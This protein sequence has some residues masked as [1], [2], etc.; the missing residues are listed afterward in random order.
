MENV[1]IETCWT[2]HGEGYLERKDGKK[3][4]WAC[5]GS[6]NVD[7]KINQLAKKRAIWM[8]CVLSIWDQLKNS[9]DEG[10]YETIFLTKKELFLLKKIVHDYR[11]R[12]FDCTDMSEELRKLTNQ[13]RN[14]RKKE[15][16]EKEGE[17]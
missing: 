7:K 6:G 1:I 10:G 15:K 9:V 14:M 8:K 11:E 4:C 17:L 3:L 12:F 2:C 13:Y 16:K 5:K